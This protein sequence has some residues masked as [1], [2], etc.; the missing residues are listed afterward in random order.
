MFRV[1]RRFDCIWSGIAFFSFFRLRGFCGFTR[2]VIED[3]FWCLIEPI[4]LDLFHLS[5]RFVT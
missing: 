5:F 2:G 3:D 1:M 4:F